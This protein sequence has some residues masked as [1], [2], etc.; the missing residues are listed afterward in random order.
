MGIVDLGG[1]TE[2]MKAVKF[3]SGTR[4]AVGETRATREG[5]YKTFYGKERE[6]EKKRKKKNFE[7]EGLRD[8]PSDFYFINGK[9]IKL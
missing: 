7:L 1:V 5:N 3:S 4:S 8:Q 2:T 9:P 6:E